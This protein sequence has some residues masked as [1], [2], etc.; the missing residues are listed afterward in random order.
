MIYVILKNFT[1]IV[2]IYDNL[3]YANQDLKFLQDNNPVD[4]Y[5]IKEFELNI[6]RYIERKKNN[7][8]N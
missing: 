4:T 6:Y 7:D 2:A 8:N 5:I 1:N 3:E